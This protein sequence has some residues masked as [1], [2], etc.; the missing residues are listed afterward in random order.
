VKKEENNIEWV[1]VFGYEG[2]YEINRLGIVRSLHKR[3]FKAIIQ[4]RID[5]AGYCTVRLSKPGKLNST[6]YVHRLLG[7]IF[8]DN[9]HQKCCI[10]HIDG[11]KL[12]N[13]LVN[14]EWM[15]QAEN[16]HHAYDIGLIVR[17]FKKVKD[18]CS[19]IIYMSVKDAA[20]VYNINYNTLRCYLNGGIKTNPT[21]LQYV[22]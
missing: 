3:N 19:D 13:N 14:L 16:V 15:T 4:Q 21:C 10:N 2:L 12:N 5:R 6:Y 7:I 22:A 9:P 1:Q 8:I 17:K 18:T 20:K 11:N